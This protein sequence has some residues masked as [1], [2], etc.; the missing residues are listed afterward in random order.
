[1]KG[2][3]VLLMAAAVVTIVA[4]PAAAQA[5]LLENPGFE[6]EGYDGANS[7][8]GW[9]VWLGER[10]DEFQRTGSWSLHGWGF[11]GDGDGGG[12][13]TISVTPGSK[14]HFTGYLM[15]PSEGGFHKSPLAGGAEAFLE[16]EWFQGDTKLSSIKSDILRGESDWALYS[17]AGTAPSGID[18]VRFVAKIQSIPGSS[19]DVYFDDLKVKVIEVY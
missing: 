3:G 10:L 5:N 9:D 18:S 8:A 7:T 15:S 16:I 17:A 6:A 1:M 11:D 12:W 2:I 4:M 19:G 13:Q 14:V